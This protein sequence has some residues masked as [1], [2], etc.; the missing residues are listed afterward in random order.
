MATPYRCTITIDGNKFDAISTSFKIGSKTDN[1]NLPMMGS[2]ESS[3]MVYADFHDI[4]NLPFGV[5]QSLFNL[6]N[7]V[8]RDK[9]KPMKVEYWKDDSKQDALG[10]V[11]FNGWISCFETSNLNE[12]TIDKTYLDKAEND[13]YTAGVP[14]LLNHMLALE[15]TPA[16]NQKN[17]T[18]LQFSN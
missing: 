4:N 14:Q 17:F 10:A 7:V 11:Q 18:N 2:L 3:V 5:L 6:A 1:N 15:L 12:N 9:I 16:L 8:T 13:A